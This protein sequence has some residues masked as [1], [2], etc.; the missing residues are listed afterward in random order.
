M[1]RDGVAGL[2]VMGA[3][4]EV[5]VWLGCARRREG[6]P[7]HGP[8][9][10]GE[11]R[12]GRRVQ[13]DRQ[14]RR[15]PALS[16][17]GVTG[18]HAPAP[19]LAAGFHHWALV[20][21]C[22]SQSWIVAE[23]KLFGI[24]HAHVEVRAGGVEGGSPDRVGRVA[25][26]RDASD[27]GTGRGDRAGRRGARRHGRAV[28][29]RVRRAI[30][31]VQRPARRGGAT[32]DVGEGEPVAGGTRNVGTRRGEDNDEHHDGFTRTGGDGPRRIDDRDRRVVLRR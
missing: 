4:V 20:P 29:I 11:R 17:S 6:D 13:G 1:E 31:V 19:A 18:C 28:R 9:E 14:A 5:D 22:R 30:A 12:A 7:E 23:A 2:D 16:V 8:G 32:A 26:D 10:L 3:G 15:G 27:T 25:P 24:R 21:P